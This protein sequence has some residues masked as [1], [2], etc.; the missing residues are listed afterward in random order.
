MATKNNLPK[1]LKE[2]AE[3]RETDEIQWGFYLK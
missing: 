1:L 3:W 2:T